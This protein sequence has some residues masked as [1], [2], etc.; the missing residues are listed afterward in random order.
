MNFNELQIVAIFTMANAMRAADGQ[1]QKEETLPLTTFCMNLGLDVNDVKN[2]MSIPMEPITAA[3]IVTE[4]DYNQ[5]K[6]V[7]DL[8]V[9]IMDADGVR[10]KEEVKL[11]NILSEICKLPY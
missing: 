10:H 1:N 5:K 8:L 2:Y 11:L 3:V 7:K 6:T 9:A 4:M